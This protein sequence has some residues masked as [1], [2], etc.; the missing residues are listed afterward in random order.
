MRKMIVLL[1]I[2]FLAGAVSSVAAYRYAAAKHAENSNS[3]AS[4]DFDTGF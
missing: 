4:A 2:A 1:V 3:S